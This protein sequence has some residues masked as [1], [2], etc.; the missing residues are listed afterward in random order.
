MTERKN[1]TGICKELLLILY[2]HSLILY[3]KYSPISVKLNPRD[4]YQLSIL[5]ILYM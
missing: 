2:N 3:I 1:P 5:F 4:F